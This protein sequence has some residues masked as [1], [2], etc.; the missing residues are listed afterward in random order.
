MYSGSSCW[1]KSVTDLEIKNNEPK[2]HPQGKWD[3]CPGDHEWKLF[4]F[5]N[6]EDN[7][8]A[9][10]VCKKCGEISGGWAKYD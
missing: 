3:F 7:H 6:E 4:C 5:A 9:I 2:F 8:V 10:G 1:G